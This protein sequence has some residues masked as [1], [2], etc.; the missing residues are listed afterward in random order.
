MK[1]FMLGVLFIAIITMVGTVV[2]FFI[3]DFSGFMT[4]RREHK[5]ESQRIEQTRDIL[6][7]LPSN[8]DYGIMDDMMKSITDTVS[9]VASLIEEGVFDFSDLSFDITNGAWTEDGYF[10]EEKLEKSSGQQIISKEAK[11]YT[12]V[13]SL[14][15]NLHNHNVVFGKTKDKEIKVMLVC[16]KHYKCS[17]TIQTALSDN[18][19]YIITNIENKSV[20]KGYRGNLLSNVLILVPDEFDGEIKTDL[21]NAN[22]VGLFQEKRNHIHVNNGNVIL[23]QSAEQDLDIDVKNGNIILDMAKYTDFEVTADIKNGVFIGL[24]NTLSG[25]S[26]FVYGSGQYKVNLAVH[27]GNVIVNEN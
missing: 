25:K 6:D 20:S 15:V 2:S 3:F 24:G 18:A 4:I 22:Y 9:G 10:D 8:V 23:N 11:N 19:E 7:S 13:K 14:N 17:T 12:E 5:I 26:S 16:S 27:N 1:K 21:H